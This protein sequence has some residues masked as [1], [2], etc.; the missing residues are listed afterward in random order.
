MTNCRRGFALVVLLT[1]FWW[2]MALR[3]QSQQGSQAGSGS[4]AQQS[5]QQPGQQPQPQAQQPAPAQASQAKPAAA[6][7][8]PAPEPQMQVMPGAQQESLADAARR[9]KAQKAKAAAKVVTDEDVSRL[10]GGG[11]SVVGDGSTGSSDSG[12]GEASAYAAQ[13]SGNGASSAS[14]G[15]AGDNGEKYWRGRAKEIMNQIAATDQQISKLKDDIAKTGPT[16]V[17]PTTGLTQNVIIIHDRNAQLKQLEDRKAS[18]Q[19]QLDDLADEGRR[20]GADSSWF[21]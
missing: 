10:S 18:L 11:V 1:T 12:S 17:D 13:G 16:G 6:A 5:S 3:A 20:A 4:Q 2:G 7:A 21:R 15:Q 8:Q 14:P 19:K 9:M